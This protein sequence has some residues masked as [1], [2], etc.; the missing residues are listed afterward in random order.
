MKLYPDRPPKRRRQ[1][2][3]R[4]PTPEDLEALRRLQE[5]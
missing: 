5:C 3:P 4:P 2:A 1:P